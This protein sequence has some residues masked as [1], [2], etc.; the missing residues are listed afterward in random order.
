MG[1]QDMVVDGAYADKDGS[2]MP[3]WKY[4]GTD[5]IVSQ[6][7]HVA[8][9]STSTAWSE[10]PLTSSSPRVFAYGRPVLARRRASRR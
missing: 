5:L 9:P 3:W 8:Q 1:G 6:F 4:G 10:L 2:E 7:M